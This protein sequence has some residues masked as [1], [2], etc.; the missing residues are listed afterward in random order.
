MLYLKLTLRNARRAAKDYVLYMVTLA[1]CVMLFYAFLSISSNHYDPQIGSEFDLVFLSD[2]MKVAILLLTLL[3]LFLMYY[4]NRFMLRRRQKEFA[5]E[6]L[7]GMAQRTIGWLFFLETFI[8]G[9]F[10]VALGVVLGVVCSQLISAMLLAS[11][12]GQYHFMWTLFPDTLLWTLGFFTVSQM[13]IGVL[14]V[15]TIRCTALIDMFSAERRNESPQQKRRWVLLVMVCYL[16]FSAILVRHGVRGV[17]YD[18][19]RL[20][21]SARLTI[22]A[23]L[24]LPVLTFVWLIVW[25]VGKRYAEKAGKNAWSLERLLSGFFLCTLANLFAAVAVLVLRMDTSVQLYMGY[26]ATMMYVLIVIV[27]LVFLIAWLMM[28]MTHWLV[29]W[30]NASPEHRYRGDNL[31]FFGQLTSKLTSN[32]QLMTL[33]C[34]TLAAAV[35]LFLLPPVFTGWASGYLDQRMRYEVQMDSSYSDVV[36]LDDLAVS[37]DYAVVSDFLERRGVVITGD[38]TFHTYLLKRDNF[39]NRMKLNFPLAAMALSDYNAL[40]TLQG[41]PPV[42]LQA[43]TFT[44]QW[45]SIATPE[46]RDEFLATHTQIETDAGK[47]TLATEPYHEESIGEDVYNVHTDVVVVLP[48]DVANALLPIRTLRVI[49]TAQPL[50][51]DDAQALRQ[52]FAAVYPEDHAQGP[53]YELRLRTIENNTITGTN[54]LLKTAMTYAAV[55]LMV[56]CLTILALG[57]LADAAQYRYRFAVLQRLGV[58]SARIR[59]LVLK[60]LAFWFGLPVVLA[61]VIAGLGVGCFLHTVSA[62]IAA[63]INAAQLFTQLGVTCT[64]LAALLV[65]Y[66]L[67][68]WW[69]FWRTITER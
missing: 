10:A 1:I 45:Q 65:C 18:D 2:G 29:A 63:Y 47:L 23:N 28:L 25:Y 36:A 59:R 39:N 46:A 68:T 15:R 3:L 56:M 33:I 32:T 14:S 64:I 66:F 30:K 38:H 34:L 53:N 69:L 57:Q 21:F 61:L 40:C 17:Q 37:E 5:L 54:V 49:E 8:M 4:V 31:F 51:F 67:S 50:S 22:W 41:L 24:F 42:T 11:Y 48:D 20:A 43:G 27:Q 16:V 62:E 19:V 55:V 12:G 9:A 60:Q 6:A 58:D 13:V 44:T 35:V 7:M 52:Q 26:N